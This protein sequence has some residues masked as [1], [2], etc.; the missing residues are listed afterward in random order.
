MTYSF[1]LQGSCECDEEVTQRSFF[2]PKLPRSMLIIMLVAFELLLQSNGLTIIEARDYLCRCYMLSHDG[3][4]DSLVFHDWG[5]SRTLLPY[6]SA[7]YQQWISRP[8]DLAGPLQLRS[9]WLY[10]RP[11]GGNVPSEIGSERPSGTHQEAVSTMLRQRPSINR[12][13]LG[14]DDG[15]LSTSY[16]T[17]YAARAIVA[18]A[19]DWTVDQWL[20]GDQR[21][22]GLVLISSALPEQAAAEINRVGRDDRMVGVALGTNALG[23]LFGDP[24]YHP[25]YR[26]A[27]EMDLP[28]VLQVGSDAVTDLV[29]P[30]VAGGLPATFAEYSALG[31]QSLM[32]HTASMIL[33]S[34]FDIFPSLKVLLVGGGATWIPGF[35]WRL[36]YWYKTYHEDCQ[37]V[38]RLPSDYFVDHF[39][40]CTYDLEAPRQPGRLAALL[41]ALPGMESLL[42]YGSGYPHLDSEEPESIASR[43]PESWQSKFLSANA[44]TF[45]RWPHLGSRP[46][47]ES[48]GLDPNAL[49][50]PP[51]GVGL[52]KEGG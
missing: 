48:A 28:L 31:A 4:V 41:S 21:L 32:S 13:V 1:R 44:T 19:N 25:I 18:A 8:G 20:A 42:V 43:L 50:E 11:G 49:F 12:V 29:V 52:T 46:D 14:Y 51:L 30:P 40:V 34:V 22:F 35:L 36:D 38:R 16:P 47:V 23:R 15:L 39:R 27:A 5:P 37:W 24:I 45:F 33:E 6:M 9:R 7:A 10:D 26:A 3:I 17:R 2:L